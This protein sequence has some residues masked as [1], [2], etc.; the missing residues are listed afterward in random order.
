[1]IFDI[2]ILG[3]NMLSIVSVLEKISSIELHSNLGQTISSN[4]GLKF[5]FRIK[6]NKLLFN[7]T[8]LSFSKLFYID[9]YRKK[10]Q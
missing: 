10:L 7:E 2:K 1:M 9:F 4:T 3:F 5:F 6:N 8:K